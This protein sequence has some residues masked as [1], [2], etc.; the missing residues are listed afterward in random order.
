MRGIFFDKLYDRNLI[1]K[2]SIITMQNWW[3]ITKM[4]KVFTIMS[5]NRNAIMLNSNYG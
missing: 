5:E 4:H 1:M 3:F 2:E